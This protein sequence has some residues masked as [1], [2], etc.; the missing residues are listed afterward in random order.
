[1]ASFLIY[2]E[3]AKTWG[4]GS[5]KYQAN[6]KKT[7]FGTGNRR[8]QNDYGSYFRAKNTIGCGWNRDEKIL[9]FTKDG[10]DQGPA[11]TGISF[12]GRMMPAV[13][14][15]K[16]VHATINFGQEPF[17]FKLVIEGETKEE[18]EKRKKEEEEKRKKL[19]EEEAE[20]QK[21]LKEDER[22]SQMLAAQPLM[23]M[24]FTM[25]QALVALKQTGFSGPDA[26]SNWLIENINYN[27]DEEEDESKEEEKEEVRS[28]IMQTHPL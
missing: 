5:Y 20:R 25:K 2:V 1:M 19:Q 9:Y 15:S 22:A 4:A 23:N 3:G 7:T 11:W 8:L 13:G 26:A 17:K 6:A 24:G 14:V 21:K 27:F 28:D 12:P 10:V 18:R 16:G